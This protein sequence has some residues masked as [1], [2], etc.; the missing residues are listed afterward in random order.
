M[1]WRSWWLLFSAIW[2]VVAAIQ[3]V[4]IFIAAPEEEQWKAIQPAILAVA[5]PA[6][7]YLVGWIWDRLRRKP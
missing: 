2:L 1:G 7:L 4:T 5:V 3:V 6:A